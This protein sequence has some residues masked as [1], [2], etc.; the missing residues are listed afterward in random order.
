[1]VRM[2]YV[3]TGDGWTAED[4]AQEAFLAAHRSWDRVSRYERPEAWVR[5]VVA[6][7]SVS[8]FR[9]KLSE[10]RALARLDSRVDI[11]PSLSSEVVDLWDAVRSLPR[12]QAQVMALI[13]AEDY[14][15]TEVAE[16]LGCSAETAKTHLRRGRMAVA[17]RLGLTGEED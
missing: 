4:L 11:S 8:L 1:M 9:R 7:R 12:R 10:R 5:R 15:L 16:I 2:A 3:L 6:N 17:Q 14:T 13:Y